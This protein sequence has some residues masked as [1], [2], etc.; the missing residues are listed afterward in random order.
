MSTMS[1]PLFHSRQKE[2][3][4]RFLEKGKKEVEVVT[5]GNSWGSSGY[6]VEPTIFFKPV[7][8]AEIVRKEVF[9]PVVVVDTFKTEEEVLKKANSTEYGLGASICTR[10]LNHAVRLRGSWKQGLWLL[11]MR[12]HFIPS[13]H[14]GVLRA[15]E[16]A[17]RMANMC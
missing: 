14:L 15:V 2:M 9:G 4:M 7:E 1:S 10:D 12:C 13:H 17:R 6:F 11:T 5:G 8:G 16:L 3:V